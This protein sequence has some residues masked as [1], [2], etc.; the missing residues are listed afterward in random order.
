MKMSEIKKRNLETELYSCAQ[1]GYCQDICPIYEAIP[2]ESASPRGKLHWIK[3][4]LSSGVLRPNTELGED[5]SKRLFQCS[6]CGRCHEVCQTTID[7]MK[8]WY[9]A[10]SQTNLSGLLPKNLIPIIKNLK[11]TRNPYGLEVDTRLDWTDYSDLDKVPLKEEAEIAYFV[12]CTTAFKGANHNIGYSTSQLLNHLDVNWTFLGEDE[13]CCGSPL[14]MAGEEEMA[15]EFATHN[16]DEIERRDI[17]LLLTGC[18]SCYRMWKM[19]IPELLGKKLS[20]DVKHTLEYFS[21]VIKEGKL[22]IP[23][24]DESITYHDPCELSRL[25]G[26][27]EEPREILNSFSRNFRE[28]P[29]HGIDVRCCGGGGLLQATD[30]ELRLS[31][32]KYRLEQAKSVNADI[33][34]S[35][36]PA[37]KLTI[38]DAIRTTND[39]VECLDLVEYLAKQLDL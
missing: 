14:L 27:V 6:L 12:G 21:K 2:W 11:E 33:I 8:I 3:S 28:L 24:S 30:N 23:P 37:C 15:K 9:T 18:P 38:L 31:I 4:S 1:C 34:T 17:K 19:E 25:G 26:V 7:T 5:F 29:E 39:N 36:C 13:W 10:R 32:A 20:F 22:A 35:A 16:I